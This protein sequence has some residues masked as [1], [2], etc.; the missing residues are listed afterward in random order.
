[1]TWCIPRAPGLCLYQKYARYLRSTELYHIARGDNPELDWI[2][3][4]LWDPHQG[5][6][7]DRPARDLVV[8]PEEK[9][10]GELI[11]WA[12]A[13]QE[14]REEVEGGGRAGFGGDVDKKPVVGD[15]D[16]HSDVDGDHVVDA[17]GTIE[18]EMAED[19]KPDADRLRD[20][21]TNVKPEGLDDTDIDT[22][23]ATTIEHSTGQA[24][25]ED[26]V[27]VR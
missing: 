2:G 14:F 27:A 15:D 12:R 19:I 13:V 8:R 18:T 23:T 10:H 16:Q 11:F 5:E 20:P 24:D 6:I 25:I 7:R 22:P 21:D 17:N 3:N 9:G 1:M 26:Q 4:S